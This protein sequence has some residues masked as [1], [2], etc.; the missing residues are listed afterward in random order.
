MRKHSIF[1]LLLTSVLSAAAFAESLVYEGKSGPGV[2]KHIVFLAGDHEYRSEE[3]LPA[4][5]RILAVHHGFKCTVL[6][7][8][9]PETGEIDPAADNLP[10]T[11]ALESADLAVAFLRFKNL[12]AA[13]MQPIID[14]LDRAGPVVGLR[15]ATHA[16]KIPTDSPFA[17]YDFVYEGE[18]YPRGFGRQ[19][20]GESW[21]GHY[22]KNHVMCTR[23]DIVPAAKSHPI[24]RG[25]AK[26]WAQSG[27]YWT[28]PMEDSTVLAMAQPLERM[29]PDSP[30]AEDKSP[31]PGVWVRQYVGKDGR[32]GRVFTTTHGASEDIVDLDFRRMMINACF[33]ACGMQDQIAASMNVDFVGAYQPSTFQFAGH[34]RGVKPS[35]LADLNTPIMSTTKPI[36]LP[37]PKNGKLKFKAN[38]DSLRQY[39]CPEWFRDAKF[40]IYLHW[41]P[42]S[43]VERGEWYARKLYEEGG[44]DYEYH[45]KTYGHPSEFGYKD[46]IPMW[47]AENFD[48]DELL[49]LFKRAG[50]KYFTPCAV[51]HDN[52]DLWD[53]K[54]H[55]WNAVKMGPEKDL[56][57]MWKAATEK[58]GLR[59]GVTTHLSRSY[60]WLNVANQADT[61]GPKKEVSYDG[62]SPEGKGLYPPKHDDTHPRA[63]LNPPKAWRSLWSRR[64]KQLINDYQPDHLYFDCSVPFRGDDAGKTGMQ[65]IA[66]HYNSNPDAVM[67]IKARP[68]QGL[69]APGIAT[70][71]YERGKA[72]HILEEPWQTDDSIGSWGYNKHKPYTTADTQTD[73]LIDIVSKNGNL[74]LNIP[75]RADGTLDETATG[76]LEDMGKWL[77]VNGEGIYGTR[78]WYIF[79]EGKTNEIPHFVVESPFTSN[80]IR[81]TTKGEYLYAFVLDWPGKRQPHVEMALLSPGN[82]R[83]G[84]I[85]SVELLGHDGEIRWTAHP[86]GLRVYFP[87]S[88]PCDFAYCFKIHLPNK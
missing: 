35:D 46:F 52:F 21:S 79:G 30:V 53:S 32:K 7:T 10:G 66:H 42:Y 16:F 59:F 84:E 67:C 48:P 64:I 55:R 27:G 63:A 83:I 86:D 9:D 41:G 6:F 18:D 61:E 78:P 85:K 49:A 19:V 36:M 74:L 82:Q 20:L 80:D 38:I 1:S 69:Y 17:R 14:Y 12:P 31:C 37:P 57:R 25:V 15:T 3:T 40:G 54:H 13:Q 88:K 47:K 8:V 2:G 70:L 4:L 23:L 28:E 77:A 71:D 62:A 45:V 68:W 81:Y 26:P 75:I 24:L 51:H 73:K 58:A 29:T 11:E 87:D 50:A 34:R 76:I 56:I 39:R 65:V 72:S 5:A 43:V 33:W 22:G 44:E 60:S